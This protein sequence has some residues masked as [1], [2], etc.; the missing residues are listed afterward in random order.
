MNRRKVLVI[1]EEGSVRESWAEHLREAV[2][3]A[4]F[5]VESIR[6]DV[7]KDEFDLLENRRGELRARTREFEDEGLLDSVDILFVD[8][9]LFDREKNL[10]E[11]GENL[12]YLARCYSKCGLIVGVNQFG[13]HPFDLTLKGHPES[14]ADLNVGA[15]QLSNPGLWSQPDKTKDT[16][17]FRPWTWPVL[18]DLLEDF[19]R[20]VQDMLDHPRAKILEFFAFPSL[21]IEILPRPVAEFIAKKQDPADT[22]FRDFVEDSGNGLRRKD[23]TNDELL[24]R[25]AAARIGKW[26]ERLVLAGQDLLVDAPHLVTRLPGLL[27]EQLGD[28][29]VWNRTANLKTP[30]FDDNPIRDYRFR[31]SHWLSRPAWFWRE[32]TNSDVLDSLEPG[33]DEEIPDL[34]FCEDR[35]EF[36][37]RDEAREF[38]ADVASPF[39]RRF[40]GDPPVEG[41]DYQPQVRFSL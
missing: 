19:N 5:E 8:Y 39:T 37:K 12:A 31:K 27:G 14:F 4:E 10:D 17:P 9:D 29:A 26:L 7:I 21:L 34:V 2:E 30:G 18:P 35:S 6:S 41:V 22:T 25:V 33:W 36:K 20:R 1:D 23:K 3:L 38:V 15:K 32:L 11:T 28:P 13:D 40:V 24:A 16:E